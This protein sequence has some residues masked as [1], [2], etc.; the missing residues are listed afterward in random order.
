M[1]SLGGAEAASKQ[2]N[3]EKM[4]EKKEVKEENSRPQMSDARRRNFSY[5]IWTL[6]GMYLLYLAWSMLKSE[7][8]RTALVFVF[9]GLFGVVGIFLIVQGCLGMWRLEKEKKA[10]Q[11]QGA[12]LLY[13]KKE[14]DGQLS[15]AKDSK[16]GASGAA[17]EKRGNGGHLSIAEAVARNKAQADG[18]D[19]GENGENAD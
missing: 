2:R 8:E 1:A 13:T 10:A 9:M 18:D 17:G 4:E 5:A 6:A 16:T 14:Q 15:P 3:K 12:E 11:K 7:E 19:D